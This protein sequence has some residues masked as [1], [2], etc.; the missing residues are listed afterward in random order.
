MT[1]SNHILEQALAFELPYTNS[2]RCYDALAGFPSLARV[3]D[4]VLL[5]AAGRGGPLLPRLAEIEQAR[6]QAYRDLLAERGTLREAEWPFD[7][8]IADLYFALFD[9]LTRAVNASQLAFDDK[10]AALETL[11]E[12]LQSILAWDTTKRMELSF[13]LALDFDEEE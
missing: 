13:L 8:C 11:D 3:F 9:S 2:E 6:A 4:K 10:A 5:P 7:C 12:A 1:D